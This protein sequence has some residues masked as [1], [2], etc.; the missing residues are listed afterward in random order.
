MIAGDDRILNTLKMQAFERAK[1]EL[2]CM[3]HTYYGGGEQYKIL[4]QLQKTFID[5][6][7]DML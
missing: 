5:E 3:L 6:I 7:E 2:K 1:A 4:S